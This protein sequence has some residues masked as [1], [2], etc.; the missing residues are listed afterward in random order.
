MKRRSCSQRLLM[1]SRLLAAPQQLGLALMLSS[2]L[3][4]ST[5]LTQPPDA[6][7]QPTALPI[8]SRGIVD[9]YNVFANQ[10]LASATN[11]MSAIVVNRLRHDLSKRTHIPTAKLKLI[12][13]VPKTW[14]DSC[15]GLAQPDELCTQALVEGW[16][17]MFSNGS[18]RWLYR[19]D[20]QGRG[21][22]LER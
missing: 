16:R 13:A 15:F 10:S 3:L 11:R 21:Y 4:L 6:L 14:N 9:H 19:T 18:Q 5:G 1:Y 17:V 2:L 12:E 8:A 22:R 7:A 20:K